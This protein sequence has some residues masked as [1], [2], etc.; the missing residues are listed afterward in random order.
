MRKKYRKLHK[1]GVCLW[2]FQTDCVPNRNPIHNALTDNISVGVFVCDCMLIQ[3][4]P[5][6]RT[7][8]PPAGANRA[9]L[10]PAPHL[11]AATLQRYYGCQ[12]AIFGQVL[13]CLLS[14]PLSGWW[15]SSTISS[16]CV[17]VWMW[18]CRRSLAKR[19]GRGPLSVQMNLIGRVVRRICD[20]YQEMHF[21]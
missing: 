6:Y 18:V 11:N 20:R 10:T 3:S 1:I 9:R 19:T 5:S 4:Y 16:V 7:C 13:K 21:K 2:G 8:C 17:S 15:G 14:F 12:R